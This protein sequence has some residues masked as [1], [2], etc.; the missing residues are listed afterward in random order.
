MQIDHLLAAGR[1]VQAVDILCDYL[2]YGMLLEV[3]E[4][5]VGG[6]GPCIAD[7]PPPTMLRAQ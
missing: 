2:F 4:G 1:L 6:V 7:C 5:P 3:C